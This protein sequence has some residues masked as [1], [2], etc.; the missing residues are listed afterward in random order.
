MKKLDG[1]QLKLF[2]TIDDFYSTN[3]VSQA[4]FK[5]LLQPLSINDSATPK[6]YQHCYTTIRPCLSIFIPLKQ[7]T[8]P[9]VWE[10]IIGWMKGHSR[11]TLRLEYKNVYGDIV[12]M[13]EIQPLLERTLKELTS[14]S[15]HCT[16]T[17]K[18]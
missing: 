7:A 3:Y 6:Y 11:R 17:D 10:S 1:F 12:T 16:P 13:E 4:E 5:A 14:I 8:D 2:C 18:N 9:K 15:H